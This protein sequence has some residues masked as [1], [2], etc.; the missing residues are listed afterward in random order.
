V[1]RQVISAVGED[2]QQPPVQGPGSLTG[3]TLPSDQSYL[4]SATEQYTATYDAAQAKQILTKAGW[5]MGSNGFFELGGKPLAFSI[6]DPSAYTDFITDDQIMSAELKKV[7]MDVTVT[8]T[9]VQKWTTDLNDGTFQSIAHWGN[10]GP[11][12]YYL[13]NNW[14]NSTLTAPVGKPASGDYERFNSPQADKFLAEYASSDSSTTQDAAIAGI[15]KIVATQLPVIPLFYGVAWDE[16]HTN[17]FTGW[18]TPTNP[19]APGE[20]TGPFNE[21]TVLHLKPVS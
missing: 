1:Y 10:S 13:Y 21:I 5:K 19:Y 17:K 7:G 18:P 9:S 12:P 16:Y 3:L 4:T 8:G 20:P 11:T 15:E 6:E 2:G 14:L